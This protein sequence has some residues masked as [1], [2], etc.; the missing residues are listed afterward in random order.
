MSINQ[1][2]SNQ[3]KNLIQKV[4]ENIKY[5]L[6]SIVIGLFFGWLFFA[7]GSSS[8]K[9]NKHET[10]EQAVEHWTCSM[11]P[12]IDEPEPGQCPICGMDLIPKKTVQSDDEVV[13][14]DEILMTQSAIKLADIRTYIVK[15]GLPDKKVYLL[16]KA[17]ADE[18]KIAE[19]TARFSGRIEKLYVNFTGQNVKRGQRLATIYS[20]ELV[21]AQKELSEAISFK[22][23]NPSFYTA[24]RNKLKLWDLSESQIN[25]IEKS[26]KP[27]LYFDILSP[28]S[29]TVT[30][31][32][33]AL[34]DYVK[35]GNAL[36]QVV[37]LTKVWV[38]FDAYE[39]D[40]PWLKKGDNVDFV[41]Q[42]L[43]GKKF[44]SKITFIDPF[45]NP[46]TRVAKVRVEI[47]NPNME[48]KPEMFADGIVQSKISGK[49]N[50][51]L[52][53][54]S[55]VLWTGKRSI[56]YIKVPGR[57]NP[58]FRMRTVD[59]G[60]EAGNFY[61]INS[62]LKKDEVIAANGVFKID[63]AAQLAGIPSMMNP[64]EETSNNNIYRLD[65][66][67][68]FVNQLNNLLNSYLIIKD[69]FFAADRNKASEQAKNILKNLK[70]V[71]MEL[72][73]GDAHMYWMKQAKVIKDKA[74]I[75]AEADNID[76]QRRAFKSLSEAMIN[77][78]KSFGLENEKVYVQ[79]CPMF[80]DNK[81]AFW[82]STQKQ[83]KNPYY[84]DLMPTCGDTKDSIQ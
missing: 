36:F 22:K 67:K 71:N 28:I 13:S 83:I 4:K 8:D 51:I 30:L 56:V 14:A 21:A 59:L 50:D 48:I 73:K 60:P 76:T 69:D 31:R 84:G 1:I 18:R 10:E 41:F 57:K 39:S 42:S 75:I 44:S 34:G 2:K 25:D 65:T 52:I 24:A 78:F 79:F 12:Q 46:Q 64:E 5:I 53:P 6:P 27:K 38:L 45:I 49:M 26:G 29:G 55:A 35:E 61:I 11:H 62:G 9:V 7:G 77:V 32:H 54:K 37:D 17:Q 16:G 3:M 19:L 33:V 15:E 20:P 40:L 82:L 80:D 66:P 47:K 68:E 43:P 63:A 72:V 58:T 81:G 23:T 70:K 74:K